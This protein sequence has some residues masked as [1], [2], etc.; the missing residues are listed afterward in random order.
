M[1]LR[2]EFKPGD[3]VIYRLTKH[4]RK[5][6]PRARQISPSPNGDDYIYLVDKFWLVDQVLDGGKVLIRTRRGKT[7]VISARD[8]NL[9]PATWWE[10]FLYG[11]HF[12]STTSAT[13]E[14]V[15]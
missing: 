10:N 8:R 6:G 9:R 3:R 1:K 2:Q 14:P 13:A 12:P 4:S 11:Q 5:P 7:R 15:A